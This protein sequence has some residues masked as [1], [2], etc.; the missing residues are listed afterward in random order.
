MVPANSAKKADKMAPGAL[1][2]GTDKPA[3]C[4]GTSK[5]QVCPKDYYC[6]PTG[7]DITECAT[8]K[9]ADPVCSVSHVCIKNTSVIADAQSTWV[10][11]GTDICMASETVEEEAAADENGDAA[12]EAKKSPNKAWDEGTPLELCTETKQYCAL[13]T[14]VCSAEAPTDSAGEDGTTG[15]KTGDASDGSTVGITA[16]VLAMLSTL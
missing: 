7:T 4:Y 14:G 2:L 10:K 9:D 13:D 8:G 1:Q 5:K 15:D 16:S 12:G 6:N 3:D 11:D